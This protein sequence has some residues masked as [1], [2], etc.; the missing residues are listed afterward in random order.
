MNIKS[1][2]IYF[3]PDQRKEFLDFA[4]QFYN[5]IRANI[6]AKKIDLGIIV[7]HI[8]LKAQNVFG[9]EEAPPSFYSDAD[10]FRTARD[11]GFTMDELCG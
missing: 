5:V 8:L 1:R 4:N 3:Q 2:V 7:R 11:A 6:R 10:V 9:S